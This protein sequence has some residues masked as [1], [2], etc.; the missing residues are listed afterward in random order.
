MYITENP[1]VPCKL[2]DPE[3]WFSKPRTNRSKLAKTLCHL[4]PERAAC[5]AS[6]MRFEIREGMTQPC[7]L[8]GLNEYERATLRHRREQRIQAAASA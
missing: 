2:H 8:G 4:C 7:T 3:L 1:D 6:T 5:L